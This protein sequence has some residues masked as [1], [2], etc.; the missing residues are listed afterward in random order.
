MSSSTVTYTSIYSDYEEPSDVGSPGVVVYGYDGIPM[1]LVDPYVEAALQAPEQAPPSQDYVS[2]PEYPP[3]P[4]NVSGLEEP[5]TAFFRLCYVADYDSKEDLEE[6]P[7]EDPTDYPADG[8][9][10]ADDES[11]NDDEEDPTYAEVTLG[12]K[13]ARIW[14]RVASP[15]THHPS[16]MPSPPMLLPS[17]THGDN[18]PEVDMP[19]RNRACFTYLIG[20]FEV[21]ESSSATAA[22][23]AGHTLAHTVNYKF[24]DTMDAS[25]CSFKS[26]SMT[27]DAQDDRALLGDQVS[28]LRRER[29]YFCLMASS[30]D[31][32]A[33]IA[34]QAW[35]RIRDE[36]R[37][38]A[39]IQ[40]E[41]DRFR[42]LVR[43]IK[44]GP[45]DGPEDAGSS[46]VYFTKMPPKK[47]TATTTT[48]TPMTDAQ[49]KMF[50]KESDEVKKYVCGLL[51]MIQGS[52]MASKPKKMQ[53]AIEFATELMDQKIWPGKRNRTKDLNLYALN[54]TTIMMDNVLSSSPIAK[55]LTICPDTVE[56]SL[57]L[58]Q[59][60][61]S[62]G[63]SKRTNPNSNVV[64][65][66]FLL[67]NRYALILFDIGADR[68]FV[69]TAFSSLIDI[70]LTI[71]DHGYD[72]ELADGRIIWVNTLIRGCTLNFLNHPFN[73]DLMPV[74]MGSFDVII[75]MEWLSKYH[76]VIVC[77]EKIVCIPFGNET[78]IVH[79]N[80][81]NNKHGRLKTS[82]RRRDLKMYLLFEI[83]S[84]YFSR[85][86]RVFHQP[87]KWN[88]NR[89]ST[90]YC[91]CSIGTLSIGSVRDERIIGLSDQLHEL[92]D[93][94]FIRPSSSPREDLVLFVKKKDGSF[95]MCIDY[96]ELNKLTVKNRYSLPR[97]DYL[98]DK[99]QGS[100]V[101]SKIDMSYAIWFANE[102]VVFM[103]LMNRVCKL[104]LEKF[105]IV[106]IDDILIYSKCKQEQEEHLKLILAFLEKEELYAKFSK[107][108]F[109][110]P[111]VQ[112]LDHV[113]D[114]NGIHVDPVKIE[115]IKDWASPKSPTEIRKENVVADDLSRKERIK[116]L[117]P[118][119]KADIATYVS[120]CLTC[121]KVIAEHQKSSGLLLQPEIP[122][123]KWDNI[124]IDFVTRLPRTL[125]GHDT[126]W[127]IVDRLT[128]SAYFLPM[129]EN[130]SMDELARLYMKE[131]VM[132]H[133]IL[134]SIIYDRDKRF[135]SD[136]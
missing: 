129:M 78:L 24:I 80:R 108:E 118:N 109:W 37:L 18:V 30:Y 1:H 21:G 89:F 22:R 123:W 65:G 39:H 33:V 23:Q 27:T 91:T 128:K 110:I 133:G 66:T 104:Y 14:L 64:M 48:A 96:R 82:R 93:K 29:R 15:S 102:P 26:R 117:Q 10:D 103:D 35:K 13:A 75:G 71:L 90:S 116:L 56:A 72:V 95:W 7:K 131:V 124:T 94:G 6:D 83:S 85:S 97:I 112:F 76:V 61:G 73:I 86:F 43:A 28:I 38:T 8:G 114:S 54:A 34:R 47:R 100:S 92:S 16:E 40:H 60:K 122:Q 58:Q 119:M 36:D 11:F 125:S 106:F 42:D 84:K 63:K 52:V 111:K 107:C 67:N 88:L 126:I 81:S 20:R 69:S 98:F 132:S 4:D 121:L 57:L 5:G 113:I 49:L 59:P 32:E 46:F 115:S 31:R 45:Q 99:L 68:I 136:F 17:T 53:D 101:Y 3:S 50:S 135:T 79:G 12:Y 2:G 41:N 25:I 55:G 51:D 70:I 9:D 19:L 44:A 130:D 127:V 74:E 87:D 62:R 120:K 134:V 77:D 105:M